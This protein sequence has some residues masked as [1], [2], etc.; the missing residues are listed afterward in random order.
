ML[1]IHS[2]YHFTKLERSEVPSHS[3]TCWVV[4]LTHSKF[5]AFS[6]GAEASSGSTVDSIRGPSA[7]NRNTKNLSTAEKTTDLENKKLIIVVL[8]Q[9][10]KV[11]D[12]SIAIEKT[13]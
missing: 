12:F 3:A 1:H 7:S 6:G 11:P 10:Y 8:F 5:T 13:D 9:L 2:L 4:Q